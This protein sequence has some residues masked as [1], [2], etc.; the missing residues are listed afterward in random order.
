MRY[1][2]T[3]YTHNDKITVFSDWRRTACLVMLLMKLL[4]WPTVDIKSSGECDFCL[5]LSKS[6]PYGSNAE[7]KKLAHCFGLNHLVHSLTESF[8]P[9]NKLTA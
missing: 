3:V 2:N 6:D 4:E 9:N 5:R 8:R 1:P 7:R